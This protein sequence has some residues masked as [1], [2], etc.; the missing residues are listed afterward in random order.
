M[1]L[2]SYFMYL[3]WPKTV[4]QH[5]R[6]LISFI[7]AMALAACSPPFDWRSSKSQS[8]GDTYV[9]EYPG[10]PLAAKRNVVLSGNTVELTLQGAQTQGA[11]FALG[12]APAT[13]A[14]HAQLLAQALAESFASNVLKNSASRAPTSSLAA[15]ALTATHPV[16][17]PVQIPNTLG[18]F[19]FN[20]NH[21]GRLAQARFIWTAHG[22]YELLAV[23][24]A[25]ALPTEVAEQFIRSIRFE[26]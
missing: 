13:D 5:T 17:T 2:K 3:P 25:Q 6:G 23:G 26:P 19:D 14:R 20:V 22:A 8:Y 9:L 1:Q 15:N 11:Q 18:A 10:K 16:F 12:H 4:S 21:A 24:D 7:T